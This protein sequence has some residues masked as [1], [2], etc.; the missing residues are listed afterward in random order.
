MNP[1]NLEVVALSV[2]LHEATGDKRDVEGPLRT[3]TA[4]RHAARLSV[5]PVKDVEAPMGLS[6]HRPVWLP[7]V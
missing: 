6:R 3:M 7:Y 2:T 1:P 4:I 5:T